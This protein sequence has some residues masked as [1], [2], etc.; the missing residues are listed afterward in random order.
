MFFAWALSPTPLRL[1]LP[2]RASPIAMGLDWVR[3]GSSVA[4]ELLL[5]NFLCQRAVQTQLYIH[6]QMKNDFHKDWLL[7]FVKEMGGPHLSAGSRQ[8]HSHM[9]MSV[10][11]NEFLVAVMDAPDETQRIEVTW[12]NRRVGGGSPENPYLAPLKPMTYSTTVSP[13]TVGQHLLRIREQLANEWKQDLGLLP[14]CNAELRR[15]RSE[16]VSHLSDELENLQY[17]IAP[18]N[19]E[20]EE[21]MNGS[22]LRSANF[23]LLKTAVTHGALLRLQKEL[24]CE[25]TQKHAA[26]WLARFAHQHGAAFRGGEC[27]WRAGRDFLLAMMEQPIMVGRSLGGNPRFTDPLSMA[28]RLMELREELALEWSEAMQLVPV[29]H[30]A[31]RVD[32]HRARLEGSVVW[33]MRRVEAPPPPGFVWAEL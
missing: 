11:W 9:A 15:H 31:L 28:E 7:H 19:V 29:E 10:P 13:A 8:L 22:P 32:E 21:G 18:S 12:G 6:A 30:I 5:K 20:G 33:S 3:G 27:G 4:E 25:P 23:D 16:Q 17:A 26:E 1:P 14:L 24:S 2:H